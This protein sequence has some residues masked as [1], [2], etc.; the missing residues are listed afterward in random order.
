MFVCF[1]H[2]QKLNF[3]ASDCMTI[4]KSVPHPFAETI[5][6]VCHAHTHHS[7]NSLCYICAQARSSLDESVREHK[8]K[9]RKQQNAERFDRS[10]HQFNARH[11]IPITHANANAIAEQPECSNRAELTQSKRDGAVRAQQMNGLPT[12]LGYTLHFMHAGA[13][14]APYKHIHTDSLLRSDLLSVSTYRTDCV[15]ETEQAGQR[16]TQQQSSG[17]RNETE[18]RNAPATRCRRPIL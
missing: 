8:H 10:H 18:Q 7:S 15:R 12:W 5:R 16:S 17:H 11:I 4:W 3:P 14:R 1:A 6:P 13:L 9:R 2:T